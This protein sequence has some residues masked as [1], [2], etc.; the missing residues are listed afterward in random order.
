[1]KIRFIALI[2]VFLHFSAGSFIVVA[3]EYP[4]HVQLIEN[5]L[6]RITEYGTIRKKQV[7]L[8]NR[9]TLI[10]ICDIHDSLVCSKHAYQILYHVRQIFTNY[11]LKKGED[12]YPITLL[13]E[14]NYGHESHALPH[15]DVLDMYD[16]FININNFPSIIYPEE[17]LYK[18][19]FT[20][21]PAEDIEM[22]QDN[23]A[24]RDKIAEYHPYIT[25]AIQQIEIELK[26]DKQ[27]YYSI[28]FKRLDQLKEMYLY[29]DLKIFFVGLNRLNFKKKFAPDKDKYPN[30]YAL[31][32]IYLFWDD[33][34]KY[35]EEIK[36]L[37]TRQEIQDTFFSLS[38]QELFTKFIPNIL[39][40]AFSKKRI[41]LI[42]KEQLEKKRQ[43]YVQNLPQFTYNNN[44]SLAY[45]ENLY[46]NILDLCFDL[47]IAND[48]TEKQIEIA[49]WDYRLEYEKRFWGNQLTTRMVFNRYLV[50]FFKKSLDFDKQMDKFLKLFIQESEEPK[51]YYDMRTEQRQYY[52]FIFRRD[53]EMLKNIKKI[54]HLFPQKSEIM[55]MISG[56]F[57]A[58]AISK[59]IPD[60]INYIEIL[61]IYDLAGNTNS[62]EVLDFTLDR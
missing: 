12:N 22:Y 42:A 32:N 49:T 27:E 46:E 60:D 28:N 41:T 23:K 9:K 40:Y 24:I 13:S 25:K 35:I 31:N 2:M 45:S 62:R 43:Y 29:Q 26:K 38:T 30:V 36:L 53:F 21:V 10:F 1:M 55:M 17:H 39:G 5:I 8:K 48:P 7:S 14:G 50:K 61:P 19:D 56:G 44:T 54:S 11:L 57:H 37:D 20:Q 59:N 47:F 51:T 33:I 58:Q 16:Y 52:N 18:E 4:Q 15:Q 3:K 34:S 6:E